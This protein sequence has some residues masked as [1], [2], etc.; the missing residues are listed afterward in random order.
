M[1]NQINIKDLLDKTLEGVE[2]TEEEKISLM[3]MYTPRQ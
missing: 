2:I 3:G 1:N